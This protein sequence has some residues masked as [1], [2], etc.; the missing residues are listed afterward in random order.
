M[1]VA[2]GFHDAADRIHHGFGILVVNEVTGSTDDSPVAVLGQLR[3]P[4]LRVI[5]VFHSLS[6]P[7]LGK[8]GKRLLA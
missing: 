7:P 3:M 6:A 1:G 8:D 4:L 2:R 5:H